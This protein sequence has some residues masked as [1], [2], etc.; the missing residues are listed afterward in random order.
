MK[1]L[2][3]ISTLELGGAERQA[4]MLAEH[5]QSEGHDIL[6][7]GYGKPGKAAVICEEKKIA[8]ESK[9][10]GI[11]NLFQMIKEIRRYS[12]DIIIPFCT[13]PSLLCALSWRFTKAHVCLWNERDIG[14]SRD[15]INDYPFAIL[16]S[17]CVVTNSIHGRNYI[18]KEYGR[19][20]DVRVIYNGVIANPPMETA[21]IWK[22]RLNAEN[23]SL[24]VCM[25]SN[26]SKNKNHIFLL[27]A[28]NEALISSTIPNDSV[29]VLAGRE[30]DMA[31]ILRQYV[32]K[33]DLADNVKFLG[34]VDDISGLLS[35][36]DVGVLSSLSEGQPNVV[37]EYMYAGLPIIASDIPG[38]REVLQDTDTCFFGNDSIDELV[39][40]FRQMLS[41]GKRNSDG[42]INADLCKKKYMPDRMFSD[43]KTLFEELMSQKK[44]RISFFIWFLVLI[45]FIKRAFFRYIIRYSRN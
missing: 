43:Y 18:L 22:K 7:W 8:W 31:E 39:S 13:G 25:V 5:L 40:A 6:L 14:L 17:T 21:H 24:I 1:I 38:A 36:V 11:K 28:W 29:L 32:A 15:L 9:A 45:Y 23:S 20:L 35:A 34:Q 27:N 30:D 33:N 4:L 42:R 26:L 10:F 3:F 44:K 12:P 37:V 41:A 2:F 19:D 16:L